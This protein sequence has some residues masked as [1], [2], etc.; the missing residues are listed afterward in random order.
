MADLNDLSVTSGDPL[1]YDSTFRAALRAHI[2]TLIKTGKFNT[3]NPTPLERMI[4]A[5]DLTAYL[6]TKG[7]PLHHVWL[8]CFM[9]GMNSPA[10]FGED[11]MVIYTPMDAELTRFASLYSSCKLNII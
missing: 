9:N 6:M 8:I 2:P 11:N 1:F 7:I 4:Y 5:G 3:H 10:A